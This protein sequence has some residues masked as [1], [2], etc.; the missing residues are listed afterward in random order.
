MLRYSN[1]DRLTG[2]RQCV[3]AW[4][5]FVGFARDV[6]PSR[7]YRRHTKVRGDLGVS[8]TGRTSHRLGGRGGPY[9]TLFGARVGLF[10]VPTSPRRKGGIER[11]LYGVSQTRWGFVVIVVTSNELRSLVPRHRRRLGGTADGSPDLR[12]C[13]DDPS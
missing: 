3:A 9:R 5:L 11:Y 7:S 2:S 4:G 8:K 13:V 6:P 10:N 12:S 1:S